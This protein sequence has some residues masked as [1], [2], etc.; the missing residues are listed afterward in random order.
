MAIFFQPFRQY[1]VCS[2]HEKAFFPYVR[3]GV[4]RKGVEKKNE[5][6]LQKGAS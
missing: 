6:K 3:E 4:R 1:Q 2:G 5:R